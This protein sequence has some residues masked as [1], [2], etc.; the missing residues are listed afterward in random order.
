M[1]V[2]DELAQPAKVVSLMA[3]VVEQLVTSET[4]QISKSREQRRSME[5]Y[6]QKTYYK[7]TSLISNSCKAVAIFAGH[8]ADV[9]LL[10]HC[11]CFRA[12]SRRGRR[13]GAALAS[14]KYVV[15]LLSQLFLYR[16]AADGASSFSPLS[17]Q[18]R[19]LTILFF[20]CRYRESTG[21]PEVKDSMPPAP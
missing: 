7:T 21:G 9:S 17:L 3:T 16:S 5:Y 10:A 18:W 8:T 6:L 11:W 15:Q 14:I 13:R 19:W 1:P 20:S 2:K 12:Q 4:M